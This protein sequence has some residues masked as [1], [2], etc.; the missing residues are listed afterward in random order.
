MNA[1]Q[2][3]LS[4]VLP[5]LWMTLAPM[6]GVQAQPSGVII[7]GQG[8]ATLSWVRP[9]ENTDGSPLAVTDIDHFTVYYGEESRTGR[10]PDTPAV[11]GD[12]T[13]YQAT[14]QVSN[15]GVTSSMMNFSLTEDTTIYF[16]I[17]A[18]HSNGQSS[19]YSG[20]ATK[21]FTVLV[22]G[23]TPEAPTAVDVEVSMT[24][25]T[26]DAAFTCTIMV[27]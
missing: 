24:C 17:T 23:V 12:T 13:C 7:D 18:V 21:T 11:D 6:T 8:S 5:V 2:K 1:F 25:M 10:C 22:T 3:L 4:V 26:D 15:G 27:E 9:T 16:A 20:E 14:S 19:A